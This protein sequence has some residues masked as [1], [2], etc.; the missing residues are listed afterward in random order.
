MFCSSRKSSLWHD[1]FCTKQEYIQRLIFVELR[2]F[3]CLY[4]CLILLL[5]VVFNVLCLCF[6]V[7]LIYV[8]LS[9]FFCISLYFPNV[10]TVGKPS[11]SCVF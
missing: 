4:S 10:F 9:S 5:L 3:F 2:N 8:L 7:V 6:F 11:I 1:L